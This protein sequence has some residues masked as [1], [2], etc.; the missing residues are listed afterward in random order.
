MLK[1]LIC[2]LNSQLNKIALRKLESDRRKGAD[3]Y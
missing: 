2:K 3:E 1:E